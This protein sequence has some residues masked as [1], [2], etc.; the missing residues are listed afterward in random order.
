ML[1]NEKQS[2]T[3]VWYK[4]YLYSK[5]VQFIYDFLQYTFLTIHRY[6]HIFHY[7]KT[8]VHVLIIRPYISSLI[9]VITS[10]NGSKQMSSTCFLFLEVGKVI[11]ELILANKKGVPEQEF[12]S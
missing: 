10:C 11:S 3:K 2:V 12:V 4:S 6:I 9:L 8:V 5:I 1:K 7:S